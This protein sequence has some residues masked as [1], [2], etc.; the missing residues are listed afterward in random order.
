MT[1]IV[2]WGKTRLMTRLERGLNNASVRELSILRGAL[3]GGTSFIQ[4]MEAEWRLGQRTVSGQTDQ[5]H[6]TQ[7]VFGGK[8]GPWWGADVDAV[9]TE[10]VAQTVTRMLY[11]L[12][13]QPR[14]TAKRVDMWWLQGGADHFHIV[15]MESDQQITMTWVTPPKPDHAREFAAY[16]ARIAAL[17]AR[18]SHAFDANLQ[19][20]ANFTRPENAWTIAAKAWTRTHGC[21]G[22]GG[23]RPAVL[24]CKTLAKA[25]NVAVTRALCEAF[26]DR[27]PQE[28]KKRRGKSAR[29]QG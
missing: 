23:R 6:L 1:A 18:F 8:D 24:T 14:A 2:A 7:H 11:D 22:R 26:T 10:G 19:V 12:S 29:K 9:A 20:P 28:A 21:D 13:D 27:F 5:N 16:K 15:V 3:A 25:R 4:V 17:G